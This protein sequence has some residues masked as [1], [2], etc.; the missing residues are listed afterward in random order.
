MDVRNGKWY[1]YLPP[2]LRFAVVEA[3]RLVSPRFNYKRNALRCICPFS[4]RRHACTVRSRPKILVLHPH[5]STHPIIKIRIQHTES[6][7]TPDASSL[8]SDSAHNPRGTGSSVRPLARYGTPDSRCGRTDLP[9]PHPSSVRGSSP[10]GRCG[11]GGG[12]RGGRGRLARRLHGRPRFWS[13]AG[14]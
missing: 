11:I 1:M 5:I 3:Q 4:F 10:L 7:T 13:V 2:R 6:N 12:W 14:G 8:P 9:S